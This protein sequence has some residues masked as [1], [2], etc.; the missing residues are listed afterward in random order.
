MTR[1]MHAGMS[2]Y[3]AVGDVVRFTRRTARYGR[4]IQAES[5]IGRVLCVW[6]MDGNDGI[7]DTDAGSFHPALGDHWRLIQPAPEPR[8]EQP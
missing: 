3:P 5:L 1:A 2:D 8:P 6:S 7:V 4:G